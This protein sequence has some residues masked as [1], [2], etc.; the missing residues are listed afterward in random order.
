MCVC[1]YVFLSVCLSVCC[2]VRLCP[3]G[4]DQTCC[5]D[6]L[7]PPSALSLTSE[8]KVLRPLAWA[9]VVDAALRMFVPPA[10]ETEGKGGVAMMSGREVWGGV[11]E[12]RG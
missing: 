9:A 12:G 7:R 3:C 1:V 6:S 11:G 4:F 8:R 2:S 10:G 5:S